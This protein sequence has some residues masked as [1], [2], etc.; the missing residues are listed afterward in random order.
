MAYHATT[1]EIAAEHPDGR[2]YLVQYVARKSVRGLVDSVRRMA[3]HVLRV[4]GVPE[5][6]RM[7][8]CKGNHGWPSCKIDNWVIRF[9][10]RTMREAKRDGLEWIGRGA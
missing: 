7:V 3:P 1:Y 8:E 10:G 4:L 2:K 6:A 5:D 9:T